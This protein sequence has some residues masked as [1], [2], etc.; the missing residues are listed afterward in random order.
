MTQ[1][2]TDER[3]VDKDKRSMCL[4]VKIFDVDD[5][6]VYYFRSSR[7]LPYRSKIKSFLKRFRKYSSMV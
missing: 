3:W 4:R 6:Y 2:F 1:I 7:A 5:V